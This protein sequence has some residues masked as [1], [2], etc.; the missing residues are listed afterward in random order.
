MLDT[1]AH[2]YL[3]IQEEIKKLEI[4]KAE[5][6]KELV[7]TMKVET[8]VH[9]NGILYVWKAVI[10]R[11]S[12][13]YKTLLEKAFGFMD[14]QAQVIILEMKDNMSKKSVSHRFE[15]VL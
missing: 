1:K 14:D 11:G 13:S 6:Y 3:E 2:R 9:Y 15:K 7:E 4:E 10:R 5:L 12:V 8:K